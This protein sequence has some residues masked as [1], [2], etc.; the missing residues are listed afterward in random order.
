MPLSGE[1]R[2]HVL[3][4]SERHRA[5][6]P[7][8]PVSIVDHQLFRAAE[9]TGLFS[10]GRAHHDIHRLVHLGHVYPLHDGIL[11]D[12]CRQMRPDLIVFDPILR[13]EGPPNPDRVTLAYLAWKLQIPMVG[14]LWDSG[15]CSIQ[16]YDQ[17]FP[18]CR[19]VVLMDGKS[20]VGQTPNP[21][22]FSW[23]W[24][25][26]SD[27]RLVTDPGRVRDIPVSFPAQVAPEDT[28]RQMFVQDLTERGIDVVIPQGFVALEAFYELHHRS[29]IAINNATTELKWRAFECIGC[30]VLHLEREG[31]PVS[32]FFVP[33]TEYVTYTDMDDLVAKIQYYLEH[34]D[35]RQ[36]IAQAGYARYHREYSAARWW[37]RVFERAGLGGLL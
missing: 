4:I 26:P 28:H 27:A 36:Q 37:Q 12:Y 3:I 15:P 35:E 17:Y 18:M 24:W 10:I 13:S 34:E 14:L 8:L 16:M 2:P 29:K 31:S 22:R 1:T 33:G 5:G 23:D 32:R 30:G 25:M 7:A 9:S 6:N 19:H 11:V 20:P 21:D